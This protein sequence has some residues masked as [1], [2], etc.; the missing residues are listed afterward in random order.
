MYRFQKPNVN[1]LNFQ[2]SPPPPSLDEIGQL[3]NI[4]SLKPWNLFQ[5]LVEKYEWN[6]G[7]AVDFQDFLTK[8]LYYDPKRR[9][10]A[11]DCLKHPWLLEAMD[12]KPEDS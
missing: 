2:N 11:A 6:C 8:M 3:R 10:T 9:A 7:D 4:R 1:L 5:V 12:E